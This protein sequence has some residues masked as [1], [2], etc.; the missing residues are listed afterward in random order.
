MAAAT[1]MSPAR[2]AL[3]QLRA[4]TDPAAGGGEF[5]GPRWMNTGNPVKLPILRRMGMA[6]AIATLWSVSEELTG[7]RILP[8]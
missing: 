6:K 2:G 3:P 8:E 4:A 7:E 1:G 5:Y